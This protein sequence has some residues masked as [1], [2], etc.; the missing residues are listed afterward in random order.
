MDSNRLTASHHD[1]GDWRRFARR[2]IPLYILASFAMILLIGC[3]PASTAGVAQQASTT[4]A[5][6]TPTPLAT[7]AQTPPSL[8]QQ[9]S[10]TAQDSGRTL[11]YTVTSRFGI[12]LN[13]QKYPK[14]HLQVICSPQDTLGSISNIPSVAPPLYA[15]RY[16]GVEP[17]ICTIK[18]GSFFLTVR[19]VALMTSAPVPC[20]S[21]SLSLAF[22]QSGIALG[23]AGAQ[24][25]FMNQSP[26]SCTLSGY[27]A[28]QLLDAQRQPMRA[29]VVQTTGAY[30]YITQPPHQF[31]LQARGKAYFVVEWG[32]IEKCATS[33]AFLRITPS[34]NQSPLLIAF[35]FC[36]D[37][38]GVEISPLE[39]SKVLFVFA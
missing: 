23:N 9:Y 15:V 25:V 31:V 36:P 39:P 17:G 37:R 2:L 16:Q 27:P 28:I 38:G 32:A 8:T 12:T 7:P 34:D 6:R 26:A 13:S 22:D 35:R 29:R 20:Q 5:G 4:P 11:T 30:L 19:I 3:A 10:F 1:I 33:A 18:N 24:F 14:S 21:Q